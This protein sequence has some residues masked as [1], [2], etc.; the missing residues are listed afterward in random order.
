MCFYRHSGMYTCAS[1]VS[2]ESELVGAV[3][4]IE[5][6]DYVYYGGLFKLSENLAGE[7]SEEDRSFFIFPDDG[8]A[9]DYFIVLGDERMWF[10]PI[11]KGEQ[12]CAQVVD[13]K[14]KKWN[15]DVVLR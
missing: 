10:L 12:T 6:E 7:L 9:T 1:A 4:D 3:R 5:F 2:R 11:Y 15:P 8:F 14:D 13:L